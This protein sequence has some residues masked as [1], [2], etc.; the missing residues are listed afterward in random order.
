MLIAVSGNV[1]SGKTTLARYLSAQYH[2]RFVPCQRLEFGFLDAFFQD[3]EGKFLP[4]QLSFLMSKAIELQKLL[5]AGESV[6]L[7]RSLLEDIEVFARLWIENRHIDEKIVTLYNYT[8]N[9]IRHA[10]PEPDLYIFC[11]CPASVSRQRIASRPP[12]DFEAQYPPDHIEMLER[13]YQALIPALDAPCVEVDTLVYDFTAAGVLPALCEKIFEQLANGPHY[14]QFSLFEEPE[15][16]PAE[17]LLFH[18]FD[19][20]RSQRPPQSR[21]APYLYLAAP[22]TQM[23]PPERVKKAEENSLFSG[24]GDGASYGRLNAAYQKKLKQIEQALVDQCRMKVH[25]PH[26]DIN[27][28]G[29]TKYPTEYV[30]PKLVE[31]VERA[32]GVVAVPGSSIGVHLELGVAIARRIPIVIFDTGDFVSSFFLPGFRELPFVKYVQVPRLSGIPGCI[33]SGQVNIAAFLHESR[34]TKALSSDEGGD[35]R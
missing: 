35:L 20:S 14:G 29:K 7:D 21:A 2:L 9:F 25:L 30:T 33:S 5:K 3:V 19:R 15:E 32:A 18:H 6:V 31:A 1:G 8:A 26:R 10:L 23:A 17:G 11:R 4:A 16:L 28:W 34:I 24:L 27:N 22:F 12:R 13:Y